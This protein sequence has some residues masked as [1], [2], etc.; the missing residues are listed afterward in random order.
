MAPIAVLAPLLVN[1]IFAGRLPFQF[2]KGSG[3]LSVSNCIGVRTAN[4]VF[5][6]FLLSSESLS[7]SSAL[8]VEALTAAIPLTLLACVSIGALTV[9][10]RL[11]LKF[12]S[13]ATVLAVVLNDSLLSTGTLSAFSI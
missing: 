8:F 9:D 6:V 11:A 3:I 13:E 5:F 1:V 12:C 2:P 7:D 4:A 10:S